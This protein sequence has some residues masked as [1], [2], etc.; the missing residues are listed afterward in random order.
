MKNKRRDSIANPGRPRNGP[1]EPTRFTA[2]QAKNEFGRVLESVLQ[3]G[4]AVITKHAAPK[5]ILIS[6]DEFQRIS[7]ASELALDSLSEEFDALFA[8]MQ[9]PKSRRAM[10]A[11]FGASPEELGK[12]AVLATRKRG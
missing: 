10:K 2:T 11:A 1:S 6:M 12:A 5:A 7:Q 8:S 9:T 3:G 4:R